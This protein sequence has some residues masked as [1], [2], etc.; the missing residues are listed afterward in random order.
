MCRL[1]TKVFAAG[2]RGI[3]KFRG[4]FPEGNLVRAPDINDVR[5]IWSSTTH[6]RHTDP[7]PAKLIN[8]VGGYQAGIH[9]PAG[10]KRPP[11]HFVPPLHRRG[12]DSS[13]HAR[14]FIYLDPGVKPQ[15]DTYEKV[16]DT[17]LNNI[18]KK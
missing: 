13:A 2:P 8:F 5:K 9:C 16:R 11:R 4:W 17:N 10:T 14:K 18:H 15:D 7:G 1:Q 12:T 3:V 6:N